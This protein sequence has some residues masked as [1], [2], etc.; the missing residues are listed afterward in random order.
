[1]PKYILAATYILLLSF[2]AIP[3]A[4]SQN[5]DPATTI[6]LSRK[7]QTRQQTIND[8]Q[9]QTS[10]R[11]IHSRNNLN[12]DAAITFSDTKLPLNAVLDQLIEGSGQQYSFD[13]TFIII[14]KAGESPAGSQ[15][16]ETTPRAISGTVS[17]IGGE[18]LKGT[19]VEIIVNGIF[20]RK[21]TTD[22]NGSFRID[23]L[24]PGNHILR[25]TSAN[26]KTIRYREVNVPADKDAKVNLV[27]DNDL[28]TDQSDTPAKENPAQFESPK[29]TVYYVPNTLDHTIKALTDQ[30]K[31]EMFYVDAS[32]IDRNY[33]PKAA[34]KTNLLYLVATTP[35]LAIEFGLARKWTLDL[36][37][38]YNPFQWQKGGV[39]RW[40]Y[41]Q[42]ELRY[43]FCQRFE[44]HFIGLHGIYGKFNI[45]DTKFPFTDLFKEHRYNGWAAGGG[46]SYG[47]H[48]P[49][50]GRWAVEF[51]AGL[52][53]LYL[54]YDKFRCYDCDEFVSKKSRHYFGPT[55]AG[56]SLIYLIK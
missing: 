53:Y 11:I 22:N 41:V 32:Q 46:I 8:I 21:A 28:M 38:G 13:K 9:A 30:P 49:I 19:T 36:S 48:L 24:N 12:T 56:I 29:T 14:H 44:K 31:T 4:H 25:L 42:P 5:S 37:A 35:N 10:Y 27:I 34:I 45:G 7:V 39:N 3:A 26:G 1:M 17:H 20:E 16:T 52:G 54:E 6:S 23:K 40:G 50:S 55:K 18:P 33:L 15:T 51:T 43:W 47:Y 2:A